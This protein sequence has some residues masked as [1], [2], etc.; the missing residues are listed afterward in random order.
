MRAEYVQGILAAE[1]VPLCKQERVFMG[2]T[3]NPSEQTNNVYK[4]KNPS[5]KGKKL[6][7][8]QWTNKTL[9]ITQTQSALPRIDEKVRL[10]HVHM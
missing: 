2:L 5:S 3:N 6:T 8:M 1:D 9:K 7:L 4:H 10:V